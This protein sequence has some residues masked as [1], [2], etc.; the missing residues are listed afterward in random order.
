MWKLIT[1][2][3]FPIQFHTIHSLSLCTC[4]PVVRMLS[5]SDNVQPINIDTPFPRIERA[6][7]MFQ[8]IYLYIYLYCAGNFAT[9]Q[10]GTR[11][12]AGGEV[13]WVEW[14][15]SQL[16]CTAGGRAHAVRRTWGKERY[17]AGGRNVCPL[18]PTP[19]FSLGC[20]VLCKDHREKRGK[21]EHHPPS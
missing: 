19:R 20:K 15:D 18:S 12:W 17:A 13:V 7:N 5:A 14:P 4:A 2:C 11:L 10:Q 16:L 3:V 6:W 21:K 8:Y 9:R 1:L